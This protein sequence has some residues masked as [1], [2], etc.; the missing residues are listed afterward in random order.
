MWLIPQDTQKPGDARGARFQPKTPAIVKPFLK[1]A[2]GKAQILNNIRLKYPD[3]FGKTI[4]KYAEPF[5]GGGAVLFDVLSNYDLKEIYISDI[6]RELILTY[7]IIKDNI[8]EI[9]LYLKEL[10]DL[11]IPMDECGRKEIYYDKRK[12]FNILKLSNSES[13]ELAALFIF[14][15]RT[16]F[17]GLFRVNSKGEF[18]VPQGS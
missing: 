15:N 18:N 10:E 6:N 11:Y 8:N 4:I 14:L 2:G 12:R 17:N 5:I 9:I 1:W 13:A 16:C 3:G 7:Q